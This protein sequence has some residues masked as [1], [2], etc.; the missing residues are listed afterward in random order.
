MFCYRIFFLLGEGDSVERRADF[1]CGCSYFQRLF[2]LS[3]NTLNKKNMMSVTAKAVDT[4]H[5]FAYINCD[6]T[7]QSAKN[8]NKGLN[9]FITMLTVSYFRDR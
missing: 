6:S 5:W 8:K 2:S 4:I 9:N 7:S 1:R 3:R